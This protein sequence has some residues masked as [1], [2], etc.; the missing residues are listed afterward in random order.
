MKS[1]PNQITTLLKIL[2]QL[3]TAFNNKIQTPQPST[4]CTPD[5]SSAS[6]SSLTPAMLW[7]LSWAP[8]TWNLVEFLNVLFLS[9][10]SREENLAGEDYGDFAEID[11]FSISTLTYA[12]PSEKHML[13]PALRASPYHH[14]SPTVLFQG[15]NGICYSFLKSQLWSHLLLDA[16]F[17]QYPLHAS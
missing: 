1:E 15:A 9:L 13:F 4:Y 6:L 17:P 5:L 10:R 8:T 12:P 11:S 7:F 14:L 3:F 2:V 16:I